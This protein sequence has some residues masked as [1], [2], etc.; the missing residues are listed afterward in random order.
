VTLPGLPPELPD[1]FLEKGR[2]HQFLDEVNAAY[3]TLRNDPQAWEEELAE[4]ALWDRA[5][6]DG[7][8]DE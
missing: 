6:D 5:L 2:R 3:A 1:P 4:R 8:K 7:L